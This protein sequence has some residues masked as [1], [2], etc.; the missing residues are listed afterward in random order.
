M[1]VTRLYED[2]KIARRRDRNSEGT[3]SKEEYPWLNKRQHSYDKKI[4]SKWGSD[5]DPYKLGLFFF[6]TIFREQSDMVPDFGYS[7]LKAFGNHYF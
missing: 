3:K 4:L 5:G 7:T 6:V 1:N 2:T